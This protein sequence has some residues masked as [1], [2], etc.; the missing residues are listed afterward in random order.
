[1]DLLHDCL[2]PA[3][4]RKIRISSLAAAQQP[5]NPINYSADI[6]LL[7]HALLLLSR[8]NV[9]ASFPSSSFISKRRGT[10]VPLCSRL[11]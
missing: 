11:I 3:A 5:D 8:I 10:S 1:M 4:I 9:H 6:Q 2:L 7:L